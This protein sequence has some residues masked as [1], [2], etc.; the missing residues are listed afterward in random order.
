AERFEFGRPGP[1]DPLGQRQL[2]QPIQMEG[3]RANARR[4]EKEAARDGGQ[5]A[6]ARPTVAVLG[7]TGE[8]ISLARRAGRWRRSAQYRQARRDAKVLDD[9]GPL[10]NKR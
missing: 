1:S 5:G 6:Q 4:R 3:R 7:D 2:G 10:R 9:T 8:T